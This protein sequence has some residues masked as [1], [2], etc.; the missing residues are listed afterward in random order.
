MSVRASAIRIVAASLLMGWS[1][2]AVAQS[3]LLLQDNDPWGYTY[4]WD[5]LDAMGLAAVELGGSEIPTVDL[6][7]YDL[8]I[9]PSQQP[10]EF[11]EAMNGHVAR[12]EEY[13]DGGGRLILM[14]ATYADYIHISSL[15]FGAW[16]NVNVSTPSTGVTNVA[17]THPVMLSVPNW[18]PTSSAHGEL[19]TI[20]AAI[21]LTINDDGD[22]TTYVLEAGVGAALV[23]T[24]ALEWGEGGLLHDVGPNAIDYLL[25][26]YCGDADGD[27][28]ADAACGGDDCDDSDPTMN[29]DDA[30]GDGTTSCDG[31][32]NDA[33]AGWNVDDADG[34]GL[35][36]CAGDC[37][38]GDAGIHPG[39][40]E[41]CDGVDNDCDGDTDDVDGDG[42]GHSA[43][44]DDCDDADVSVYPGAQEVCGDGI[45]ND[46]DDAVDEDCVDGDDDTGEAPA[47]DDDTAGEPD[48][49]C[50][51]RTEPG[52]HPVLRGLPLLLLVLVRRTRRRDR[53]L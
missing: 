28:Y 29:L 11:N 47:D 4:W 45:D 35:S 3:I 17:P 48:S 26:G 14:L 44:D 25:F 24:V 50:A 20:G 5:D 23:S 34:D 30:D 8:V 7:Q 33:N 21:P 53:S 10:T 13:L 2:G 31:D 39:A 38:D 46:C 51:C 27:G 36:T 22:V 41:V 32:C 43:C 19:Q 42:D 49:G 9:V 40:E 1:P 15:P 12:F 37:D 52:G 16:H 18:D 6:A